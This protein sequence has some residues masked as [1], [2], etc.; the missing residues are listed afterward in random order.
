MSI[1]QVLL[2][3]EKYKCNFETVNNFLYVVVYIFV[4]SSRQVGF[5]SRTSPTAPRSRTPVQALKQARCPAAPP[6]IW[7][8]TTPSTTGIRIVRTSHTAQCPPLNWLSRSSAPCTAEGQLDG[9]TSITPQHPTNTQVHS[10]FKL[11]RLK[12]IKRWFYCNI[13]KILSIWKTALVFT[14]RWRH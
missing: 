1:T 6:T 5:Y 3:T 10:K 13:H 8:S 14:Q 2:Q 4:E 9:I 11:A 7:P 12:L